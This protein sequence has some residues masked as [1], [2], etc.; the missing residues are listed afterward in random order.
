MMFGVMLAN[1]ARDICWVVDRAVPMAMYKTA[2][3]FYTGFEG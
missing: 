2:R 1:R 3:V